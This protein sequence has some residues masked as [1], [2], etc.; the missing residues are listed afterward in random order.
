VRTTIAIDD[1][2]LELA[3][4]RAHESHTTLGQVV[5]H[6]LQRLLISEPPAS[7][8]PGISFIEG[9]GGLRPGIDPRSNGS[10]Y[11]AMDEPPR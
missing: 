4:R 11:D 1:R 6:A 10:L 5:E 9:R 7:E 2:L 3:K 8:A